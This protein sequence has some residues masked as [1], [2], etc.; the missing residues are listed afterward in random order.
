MEDL[1]SAD[2]RGGARTANELAAADDPGA[3]LAAVSLGG[4]RT[5]PE[6]ALPTLYKLVDATRMPRFVSGG[7]G[8]RGLAAFGESGVG[9]PGF[10]ESSSG[11]EAARPRSALTRGDV[12]ER[13]LLVTAAA[14]TSWGG[15]L[16]QAMTDGDESVSC[17]RW[18]RRALTP[19]ARKS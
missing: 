14:G 18:R 6:L 1:V 8:G 2:P 16:R 7:G 15:V 10:A 19:A 3:A 11:A 9:G 17:T 4:W 13:S 5:E 12:R